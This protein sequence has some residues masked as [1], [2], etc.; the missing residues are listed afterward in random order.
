LLL[1][2]AVKNK[3]KIGLVLNK[4]AFVYSEAKTSI[5]DFVKQKSRHTTTSNYYSIKVKLVLGTWHILNIFMILSI[6]LTWFNPIFVLLF[7][8]KIIGDIIIIKT[9]MNRFGYNFSFNE[10]IYL[11]FLY[12]FFIILFFIKATFG[13]TNW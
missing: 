2:E 7:L 11:Q 5:K 4:S 8:I 10:I 6:F 13:K 3:L 1:R 9:M 12:E